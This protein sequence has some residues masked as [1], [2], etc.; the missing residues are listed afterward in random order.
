MPTKRGEFH[1]RRT[2]LNLGRMT[3]KAYADFDNL[4]AIER[5]LDCT[6]TDLITDV[7]LYARS[8]GWDTDSILR[9]AENHL[10]AETVVHCAK[11][12]RQTTNEWAIRDEGTGPEEGVTFHYCSEE[13]R[14][15]H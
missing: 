4:D 14:D 5:K 6:V 2:S 3:F 12:G 15:K 13:C 1:G 10:W 7:L 11:C 9:S 8:K